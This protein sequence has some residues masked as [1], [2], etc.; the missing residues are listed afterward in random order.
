MKKAILLAL[1]LAAG[2]VTASAQSKLDPSAAQ[3][4]SMSPE[5]QS[6]AAADEAETVAVII[7]MT[8]TSVLSQIEELGGVVLSQIA[9]M[10][11]VNLSAQQIEEVA[12]LPEVKRISMG[13]SNHKHMDTARVLT[14]V[15]KVQAGAGLDKA[16]DGSGVIC[17]MMDT[18]LDVNH[19]NFL[20]A[21]GTP[22]T[23]ALWVIQGRN[24][25][26]REYLTPEAIAA[27][28]TDRYDETHG[29]HVLGIMAGGYK[30]KADVVATVN[31]RNGFCYQRSDYEVPYYGVATGAE[32]APCSGTLDGNNI[33]I[34]AER[35]MKY[36]EEKG[37]P[38]VMNL[39]LG[40]NRG[41]HDGTTA[42]DRYLAE[43][44]KN[45]LITVSAGNEGSTPMS[46]RKKFGAGDTSVKTFISDNAQV[47]GVCDIWSEDDTPFKVTFTAVDTT[48]NKAV[49]T[50]SLDV[51]KTGTTG[52]EGT[53]MNY[54][55]CVVDM[56]LD[57][58]FSSQSYVIF[59][60]ELNPDNNRYNSLVTV[61]LQGRSKTIKPVITVEGKEGKTIDMYAD[62]GVYFLDSYMADKGYV[63]GDD[64]QSINDMACG[65]NIL[66]VGA[67]TNKEKWPTFSGFL[68]YIAESHVGDIADFSS[69]G[70]TF[71]GRQLPHV[72]APGQAIIASYNNYYFAAENDPYE[73]RYVVALRQD[74]TRDHQWM[75]MSGTSMAAPLVGG[76][77]ALWLQADPTLT[78]DRV[79]EIIAETAIKDKF[80]E[81]APERFG[82][83]KI[84]ALAG[85]K[86]ILATSGVNN[87]NAKS[88]ILINQ[89]SAGQFDIFA[90]GASA[91]EAKLYSLTGA[92]AA[93]IAVNGENALLG[94]DSTAPGV[95]VLSVTA[96]GVTRTQKVIVK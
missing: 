34:A 5:V 68:N 76:V 86:K 67:Y 31:P 62:Q 28:T 54:R 8:D 93:S 52:V 92:L 37:K 47:M 79:K 20:N 50:Y 80:T 74:K 24:A 51:T 64:T 96:D 38:A 88:E 89:V 9:D 2:S 30:G 19:A 43:V 3:F 57:S 25:S 32:L 82:Y 63:M 45:M 22:R 77:L 7:T 16:Y 75:E 72:A 91:I 73:G 18:G 10:A 41:P 14:N 29:T 11:I 60:N 56:S 58:I 69:Y 40:H 33:L 23:S 65:D 42:G 78:I 44:G 13:Y 95:Y 71:D 84:D 55:G 85:L 59:T 66:C 46:I 27:Y 39:S 81:A 61:L 4:V 90:P 53:S 48:T 17:G 49:Y 6:R 12:A 21:D 1:V 83:G 35:I 15:D 94:T 70:K 36:A 87:V 26:V